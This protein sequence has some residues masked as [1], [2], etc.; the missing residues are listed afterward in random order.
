[1]STQEP[2]GTGSFRIDAPSSGTLHWPKEDFFPMR[3]AE[4][5]RIRARVATM[6][7]P[8]PYLGQIGWACIGI[9]A[10][11]LLAYLPWAP[12]Y[13]EL[14]SHAKLHYA[15]V[16]PALLTIGIAAFVLAIFCLVVSRMVRA[17]ER[18]SAENVLEEMDSIYEPHDP[19]KHSSSP[20]P[21]KDQMG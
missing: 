12:A 18:S 5:K 14:P 15:G 17:H 7:N 3:H 21:A 1:M 16:S 4:W 10:S 20:V 8:L 19:G 13:A 11:S 9:G 2:E 6:T